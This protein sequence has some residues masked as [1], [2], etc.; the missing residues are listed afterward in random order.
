MTGFR[1]NIDRDLFE[2][3]A[4]GPKRVK[5]KELVRA[6]KSF[7]K[8]DDLRKALEDLEQLGAIYVKDARNV[9]AICDKRLKDKG[10]SKDDKG[11]LLFI[12]KKAYE[13]TMSLKKLGVV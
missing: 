1:V 8:L 3:V 5:D 2:L 4:K 11:E 9:Y 13:F 7:R 6:L 10:L 12:R